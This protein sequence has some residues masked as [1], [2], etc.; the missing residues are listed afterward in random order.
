MPPKALI[1]PIARDDLREIRDYIAEDSPFA[2]KKT[3]QFLQAKCYLLAH[4]PRELRC[5][6]NGTVDCVCSRLASI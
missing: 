6:M 5:A 3:L 1:T 2:A 4:N